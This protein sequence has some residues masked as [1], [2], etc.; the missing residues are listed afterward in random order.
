MIPKHLSS[1]AK[2]DILRAPLALWHACSLISVGPNDCIH[3]TGCYGIILVRQHQALEIIGVLISTD[4]LL[5][6]G[7]FTLPSNSARQ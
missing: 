1:P 5:I 2:D 6:R 4:W 3:T 7:V